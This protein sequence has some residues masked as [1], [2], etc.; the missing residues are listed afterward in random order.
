MEILFSTCKLYQ[1]VQTYFHKATTKYK[2]FEK[3]KKFY[4]KI[5]DGKVYHFKLFQIFDS[6]EHSSK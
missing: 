3:Y 6:F 5:F 2:H 1:L 4:F